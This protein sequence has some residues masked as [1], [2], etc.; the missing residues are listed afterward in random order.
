M[1]RESKRHLKFGWCCSL[2][3]NWLYSCVEFKDMFLHVGAGSKHGSNKCSLCLVNVGLFATTC[4][5]T[6]RRDIAWLLVR[7]KTVFRTLHVMF[8]FCLPHVS[9]WWQTDAKQAWYRSLYYLGSLRHCFWYS[10]SL[11]QRNVECDFSSLKIKRFKYFYF[12]E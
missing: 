8:Y 6:V 3:T 10:L 9:S 4:N 7:R 12:K 5:S 2:F 11:L 1:H